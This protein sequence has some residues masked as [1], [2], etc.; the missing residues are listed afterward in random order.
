MENSDDRKNVRS[1]HLTEF[2]IEWCEC[3]RTVQLVDVSGGYPK[4][5]EALPL[6]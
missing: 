5:L 1:K 6:C 3:T 4:K 2:S